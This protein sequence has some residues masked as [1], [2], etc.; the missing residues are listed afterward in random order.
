MSDTT[1]LPV[2]DFGDEDAQAVQAAQNA[3]ASGKNKPLTVPPG[4]TV[5]VSDKTTAKYS[6]FT[7]QTTIQQAY[8]SVTQDGGKIDVAIQ[9]RIRQSDV[10]SGRSLWA[11][12]YIAP[13]T[14]GLN[15]NQIEYREKQRGLVF[16]L[17]RALGVIPDSGKLTGAI[18]NLCFP[19]KNQPGA[20]SPLVGKSVFAEI[21]QQDQKLKDRN[22]KVVLNEETGEPQRDVKD[23]VEGW[24][25]D[26]AEAE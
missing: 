7:E 14:E 21:C 3:L 24:I 20:A 16:G 12:F 9:L 11:H 8:R 25:A 5:F 10:N 19:Q 26:D 23:Q 15:E 6:R 13:T 1:N 18:Q 22:G 4:A 2:P 17:L